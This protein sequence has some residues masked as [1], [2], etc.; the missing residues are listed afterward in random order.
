MKNESFKR[1]LMSVNRTNVIVVTF[2]TDVLHVQKEK[3]EI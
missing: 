3:L 1:W 2:S